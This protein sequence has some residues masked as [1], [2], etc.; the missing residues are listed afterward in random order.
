VALG[1]QAIGQRNGLSP[2]DIAAVRALYPGTEPTTIRTGVQ[3][4]GSIAGGVTRRWFTLSWPAN[5]FVVWTVAPTAPEVDGPAQIDWKVQT[6]RQAAQKIKYFI[7]V[8][9][10]TTNPVEFEARYAV[11]GSSGDFR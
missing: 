1:G 4:R 3:F 2:L 6:T 8:R 11:L 9:N 10:L 7:E 5:L